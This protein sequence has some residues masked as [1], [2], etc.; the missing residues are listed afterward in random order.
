VRRYDADGN[1][2]SFGTFLG[3]LSS[4]ITGVMG[5]FVLFFFSVLCRDFRIVAKFAQNTGNLKG[6]T[7]YRTGINGAQIKKEPR[8]P[9]ILFMIQVGTCG[10]VGCGRPHTCMSCSVL[11]LF[12]QLM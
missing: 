12:S 9:T 6:I 7:L 2:T 5:N 4:A 8:P 10:C 1:C 11:T 3:A